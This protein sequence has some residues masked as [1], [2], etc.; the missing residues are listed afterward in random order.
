MLIFYVAYKY[1]TTSY[2]IGLQA[3]TAE[4]AHYM[5]YTDLY[6]DVHINMKKKK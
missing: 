6:V 2:F 4:C 5:N 1:V 3:T